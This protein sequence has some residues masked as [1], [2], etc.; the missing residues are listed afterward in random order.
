MELMID[1]ML[2]HWP[3]P[4]QLITDEHEALSFGRA[5][6]PAVQ[7]SVVRELHREICSTHPLFGIECRPLAYHSKVNKDFLFEICN[8]E[9]PLV[10]VHFTWTVEKDPRWPFILRFESIEEFLQWANENE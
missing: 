4:W 1:P 8:A 3:L 6:N 2:I 7:S 10:M 9:M 5:V